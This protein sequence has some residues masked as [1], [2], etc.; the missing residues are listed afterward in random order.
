[1]V[2]ALHLPIFWNFV[3][4]PVPY[5]CRAPRSA[6]PAHVRS[7]NWFHLKT[8]TPWTFPFCF[9]Q[10]LTADTTSSFPASSGRATRRADSTFT[11]R[12]FASTLND[13]FSGAARFLPSRTSLQP[14]SGSSPFV[15]FEYARESMAKTRHLR[16][17]SVTGRCVCGL[18]LEDNV[19]IFRP[20]APPYSFLSPPLPHSRSFPSVFLCCDS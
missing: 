9:L 14:F 16:S 4:I 1:M 6:P 17:G 11:S 5:C 3:G 20:L 8:L 2:S 12:D 18:T 10:A 19:P 13:L 7:E 15:F